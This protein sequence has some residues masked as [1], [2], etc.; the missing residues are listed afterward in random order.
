M[1][2]TGHQRGEISSSQKRKPVSSC[3]QLDNTAEASAQPGLL[4]PC[5]AALDQ[6]NENNDKQHTG[7]NLD[8]RRTTHSNSSFPQ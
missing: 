3:V 8:N 7:N 1:V 6:D 4:G 5:A 2:E